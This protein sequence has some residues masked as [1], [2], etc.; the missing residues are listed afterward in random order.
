MGYTHYYSYDQPLNGPA[1]FAALQDAKKI[2]EAV[3]A[4]GIVLRGGLGTGEPAL[5]LLGVRARLL[6]R[7]ASARVI[8]AVGRGYRQGW[9]KKP[10]EEL[11]DEDLLALRG[12]GVY[13][14]HRFRKVVPTPAEAPSAR[15]IVARLVIFPR[16]FY[17]GS[18]RARAVPSLQELLLHDSLD[19]TFGSARMV[20]CQEAD[21]YRPGS[22]PAAGFL[23]SGGRKHG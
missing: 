3:Q 10:L 18:Y 2:L 20:V 7:P 23:F 15:W 12:F 11:T 4:R 17:H 9:L 21:C 5:R 13:S 19:L 1:L 6:V 16:R 14:L 22:G 8:N